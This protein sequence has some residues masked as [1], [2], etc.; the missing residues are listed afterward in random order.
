MTKNI[1][2]LVDLRKRLGITQQIMA[3]ML[4]VDRKY[5][6]M[7][8]TGVKPLSKKLAL[9]LKNLEQVQSRRRETYGS[10]SPPGHGV[11]YSKENGNPE[12]PL[13]SQWAPCP[14]CPKKDAEIK[15]LRH[16]LQAALDKIPLAN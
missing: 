2:A 10:T 4:G 16:A 14:E 12:M 7:I 8:E 15:F 9:K 11:A 13:P 5:V 3:E 6:S 1:I